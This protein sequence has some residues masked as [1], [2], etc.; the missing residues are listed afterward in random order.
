MSKPNYWLMKTEPGEFSYDD[1]E[2]KGWTHWDGV[3]NHQAKKNLASM[4]IGDLA[5]IYHSVT[6]KEIVGIAQITQESYPDPTDDTGKWIVVRVEPFQRFK[7][8]VTL[9][10][11]KDT[12]ELASIALVRQSRLSVA[13]LAETEFERLLQMGQTKL[14]ANV[15]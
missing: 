8:P 1:L 10:Q 15:K 12:P 3:R 4:K 6:T 11:V 7:Q 5:L 14:A 9:Q 13:P 2:K